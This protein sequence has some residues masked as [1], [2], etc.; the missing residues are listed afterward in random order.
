MPGDS[1]LETEAAP[2]K[3]YTF[4]GLR[5]TT[6]ATSYS[7]HSPPRSTLS[8]DST[9]LN[10]QKRAQKGDSAFHTPTRAAICTIPVSIASGSTVT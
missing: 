7:V 3:R 5:T 8:Y 10:A 6:Q 4:A 1:R 9:V 2:P